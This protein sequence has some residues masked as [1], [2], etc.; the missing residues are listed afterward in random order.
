MPASTGLGLQPHPPPHASGSHDHDNFTRLHI[1]PLDSELL[2]II[3]PAS[4]LPK[5]RN[6][7]FHTIPTF[8]ENRY[9]FVDIPKPDA[10]K[11][12]T[13]LNGTVLKG[14]K[15][16]IEPAI[17]ET[18]IE[19][20]GKESKSSK[21][22]KAK[23]SKDKEEGSSKKRKRD[24]D[25]EEGVV[26]TDRKVKRG[27]TETPDYKQIKKDRKKDK[28]EKGSKDK[29]K[30]KSKRIKSKYTEQ[31]ECLLKVRLPSGAAT[32][33]P[34]DDAA[35]RKKRKKKGKEREVTVHEFENTTRFPNFLKDAGAA[36]PSSRSA[37]SDFVE[38]KGWVDE[39]GKVVEAVTSKKKRQPS[40]S[41]KKATPKKAP[42]P[43]IPDDTSSSDASSSEEEE[44]S[45][46]DAPPVKRKDVPAPT[47]DTSSNSSDDDDDDSSDRPT[48]PTTPSSKKTKIS[49]PEPESASSSKSLRIKI[50]APKTP[51]AEDVHP[52][53]ALYKRK[54][55]EE[56]VVE[57][58]A[59]KQE[60]FTFFGADL[61]DIEEADSDGAGPS[62]TSIPP[63]PMTPFTKQDFEWRNVRSAAPTPDTAHPSRM[64]SM[65]PS[66]RD[67][68]EDED[69]SDVANA[70]TAQG[71]DNHEEE[72]DDDEDADD[73][74]QG[75]SMNGNSKSSSDFQ[76]WFWENRRELNQSWMKRRKA[77]AKEKRHRENKARASKAV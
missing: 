41:S 59:Q 19:P 6:V 18:K 24:D 50:P 76:A 16:R 58:P 73:N 15:M 38:G 5:A 54:K 12:K 49:E 72:E 36:G 10:E 14:T 9:G 77:A 44:D 47:S 62:Q 43:E 39:D 32:N 29:S 27:W 40:T 21:K 4:V 45:E 23:K 71:Q 56:G 60:P 30:D 1:T 75:S 48:E 68:D 11:L 69:M 3:L 63:M 31:E 13:K 28:A 64:Q 22:E 53:E 8:P 26:L 33:L 37:A 34:E 35:A 46:E 25:V 67:D 66:Q 2:K 42:A 74:G 52:L 61:E 20:S 55:P 7:S 17:P 51:S 70:I 65:W 57:T